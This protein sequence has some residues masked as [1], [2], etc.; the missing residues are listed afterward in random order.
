MNQQLVNLHDYLLRCTYH[1]NTQK[2]TRTHTRKKLYKDFTADDMHAL[3]IRTLKEVPAQP[4]NRR[5]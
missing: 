2:H 4:P 1:Y 3:V 5:V